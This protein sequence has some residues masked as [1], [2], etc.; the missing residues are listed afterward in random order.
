MSE[1]DWMWTRDTSSG[2]FAHT[3]VDGE[4]Q[5]FWLV[6]VPSHVFYRLLHRCKTWSIGVFGWEV[7]ERCPCGAVRFA[8]VDPSTYVR[9]TIPQILDYQAGPWQDRNTRFTDDLLLYQGGIRNLYATKG[10]V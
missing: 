6:P 7:T 8:T 5:P 3:L 10:G 1:A 4:P 2:W 9:G